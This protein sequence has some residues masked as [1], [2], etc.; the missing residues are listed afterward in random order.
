MISIPEEKIAQVQAASDIVDIISEVVILKKAGKNLTGLCPFHSEKTPSFTVSP[1]KQ[2]FYCF[3][4][5]AG[6]NVF[7]FLMKH[8]NLSFVE[9]VL[10]LSKR[11]GI[12]IITQDVSPEQKQ[13]LTEKDTLFAINQNALTFFSN[14]LL[15][16]SGK[17]AMTYLKNRGISDGII[18]EF[19]IGYAP[20]E[21]D[22]LL[23]FFSNRNISLFLVEKTGLII[24]RKD[25]T[26][27]YDRFR[28]RIIFPIMDTHM[29]IIG[30]G[31]RV[32]DD[33]KPKYLNSPESPIYSKSKSLYGIWNAKSS[34]REE[35][36]VYVVEGY[37][38]LLA[39]YQHGIKN[40]VATLGTALTHDHIKILKDYKINLVYDSDEAGFNASSRSIG[41]FLK[42]QVDARVIILPSGYDPDSYIFKFG[43][44]SFKNIAKKGLSLTSF[45]IDASIRKNGLS[46][47]GKIKT[48]SELAEPLASIDDNVGRLLYIKELSE[49]IDIEEGVISDKVKQ[50]IYNRERPKSSNNISEKVPKVFSSKGSRIERQI[51]AMMLQ[52][53]DILP[54]VE[55]RSTLEYFQDN[56]LKEIGNWILQT[57]SY[58]KNISEMIPF[59]ENDEKGKIIAQLSIEDEGW[60]Y[61]GCLKLISQFELRR[62]NEEK[63]LFQEIKAAEESND[64]ELLRKL[65]P[66]KLELARRRILNKF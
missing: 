28:N 42:E 64:L 29:Q 43:A 62:S 37:M 45:L 35:R 66:K 57:S 1:S 61:Q 34:C 7:N 10:T 53:K 22:L 13:K 39:L 16:N 63:N 56:F 15:G 47:E 2:L 58:N 52:Y 8:S 54:E 14:M 46:I 12:E 60:E 11:Y 65:L 59:L 17:K 26:G 44:E 21:W 55:K 9:S 38:D 23:N 5:G 3:G 48:I 40:V 6:G 27:F 33:S 4:C 25:K 51:I 32:L 49:R 50:V 19:K 24:P 36:S 18:K 31:G 41:I 20:N 30:F